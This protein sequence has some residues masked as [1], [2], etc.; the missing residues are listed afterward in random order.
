MKMIR[1]LVF[2]MND[3]PG[4][5]ESFLMNYIRR[6]QGK[7]ICFDFLCNTDIVAYEDE[8]LNMGCNI[9]KITARSV[10][11]KKY[12]NELESF[13]A[14]KAVEYDVIWV[15]VCSLANIDYLKAAKKYGIP[16]RVIHSHNSQNMDSKLRGILH[17]INKQFID[18]YATDFWTCSEDAGKWF[19][20]SKI[21]ASKNYKLIRNAIDVQNFEFSQN[22]RDE[23][24]R[25][26]NIC[27]RVVLGNV[28]RLHFQKN[29]M[30]LLE[31]FKEYKKINENACL[32]LIGQGEDEEKL[33]NRVGELHLE[34]DVKFL[35][36]R[37]DIPQ[38]LSA[39]DVFVFPSLFEGLS[40]VSLEVQASG[41]LIFASEQIIPEEIRISDSLFT[42]N[43]D[44]SAEYWAQC[45]EEKR[46]RQGEIARKSY[47]SEFQARGYSIEEEV[48]KMQSLFAR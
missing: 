6:M 44:E 9:Y 34:A 4:G 36:V 48:K 27:D 22:A 31:I 20:S 16:R 28:G 13:F 19:Y 38:L 3:N 14:K 18:R 25:K 35:G 42:L 26:L 41:I 7:E 17:R 30:F 33:R 43:L 1:V 8:L 11:I 46:L 2:G 32:L 15:N 5:I 40:L 37:N 47:R 29:Q 12:R 10:D 23:Y 24:R 39:M 45:I 21:L